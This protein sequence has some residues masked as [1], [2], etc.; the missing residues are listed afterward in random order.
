MIH[1]QRAGGTNIAETKRRLSFA[2]L[3]ADFMI[4]AETNLSCMKILC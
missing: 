1:D 3:D 2:R 4:T